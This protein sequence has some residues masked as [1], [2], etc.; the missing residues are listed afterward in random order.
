MK[1]QV[2]QEQKNI[3]AE[4][5]NRLIQENNQTQADIVNY[6]SLTASTVSDWCNAKKYPKVDKMQMLANYF[7]VKKSDLTAQKRS[8][9]EIIEEFKNN[10]QEIQDN[11]D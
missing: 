7:R 11:S 3:F 10:F 9:E 1:N 8:Y 5:L 4:N 6:F 2:S